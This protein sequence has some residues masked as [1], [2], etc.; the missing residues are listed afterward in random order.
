MTDEEL[1]AILNNPDRV[2]M[3]YNRVAELK[4]CCRRTVMNAVKRGDLP[5]PVTV[6]TTG[7]LSRSLLLYSQIESWVPPKRPGQK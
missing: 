2:L 5:E 7:T 4:G 3:T 1:V 6:E